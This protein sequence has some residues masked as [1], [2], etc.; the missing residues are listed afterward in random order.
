MPTF[1]VRRATPDDADGITAVLDAVTRERVY[2]AIER[3]WTAAEQGRYLASL[4]DR[5]AFHVAISETGDVVGY[6]SLDLYSPILP[7]MAHVG[8][9]GTFLL[10]AWRRNGVGQALFDT[11]RQFA[12]LAGYRKF[13]IQVRASNLAAQAFYTQLGFVECG[14]LRAQVIVDGTEDD[15]VVLEFFLENGRPGQP[16]PPN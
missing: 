1:Q 12:A 2:S 5:E 13:V 9:L 3:P 16:V 10:P 11:T 4:S 7:S 6:Q 8:A 14:R 15:E